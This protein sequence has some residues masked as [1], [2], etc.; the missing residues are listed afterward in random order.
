MRRSARTGVFV[1]ATLLL[2][3]T[4]FALVA[5]A[6]QPAA[7][8]PAPA[9]APAYKALTV[10]RIYSG[11]SLNGV[12]TKG[13]AW[14]PD[15]KQLTYLET[16]GAGK[17]A[18]TELWVMDIATGQRRMLL[19]ADKLESMLPPDA[20]KATQATGLGRHAPAEYQWA[21]GGGAL[22]FQG[23]TSLAWFDL[24]TQASRTLA[25][26]KESIADPKISPD[27]R[28]VSFV[29]NHN[30]WLISVADGKER[31]SLIGSIPKSWKSPRRIGGRR[32]LRPSPTWRWTSAK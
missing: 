25:F 31:A 3:C 11:P 20:E 32:I 6:Q 26:G 22:L 28:Y 16:K 21:L 8:A 15:S 5:N 23:P 14:A 17:E 13:I 9:V 10:D 2:C 4:D 7:R 27:G 19:S 30:L 24:K 29:R 1:R 18:K 12:L